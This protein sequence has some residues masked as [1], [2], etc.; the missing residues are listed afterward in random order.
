[1]AAHARVVDR[2]LA[3]AG[4][5]DLDALLVVLDPQVAGHTDSGGFVPAPL[6][7]IVGRDRVASQF[8]R[9][10]RGFDATLVS[11]PVNAEP[12]VLVFQAGRL[13][14]V[15]AFEIRDHVIVQIHAIANPRKLGYVASMLGVPLW[16]DPATSPA[17]AGATG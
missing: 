9:F 11:M 2:F 4:D 10:L 17:S 1:G 16:V 13:L 6:H 14:G 15:I 5:G 3:A 8:L 7:R 12:G